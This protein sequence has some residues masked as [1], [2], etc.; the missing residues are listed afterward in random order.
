MNHPWPCN[1]NRSRCSP[2]KPPPEEMR[3]TC[4]SS[5]RGHW[6]RS[7]SSL[8]TSSFLSS[9][10]LQIPLKWL[11]KKRFWQFHKTPKQVL[12]L[13]SSKLLGCGSL[14][15]E[16]L[17]EK[18][19]VEKIILSQCHLGEVRSF[20]SWWVGVAE[21]RSPRGTDGRV[22]PLDCWTVKGIRFLVNNHLRK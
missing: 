5:L 16:F 17:R 9:F 11:S 19:S 14:L 22:K 7:S 4:V 1:Y 13:S 18:S 12:D 20:F 10:F 6:F 21:R 3:L 8:K 2:P 15:A